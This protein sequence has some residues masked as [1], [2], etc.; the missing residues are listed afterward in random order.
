M[1]KIRTYK[2][3]LYPTKNQVYKLE[4]AIETCRILYNSC[5]VDRRNHYER[6]G[7]G[8]SRI[9]QQRIIVADKAR[10]PLLREVHSQVL[11]DVLFRVERAFKAFFRRL[12]E[13][14]KKAG[15]PRFKGKERYNSITYP[16]KPGFSFKEGKLVLS[17]IGHIKIKMH[18]QIEG[19]VKTCT[20]VRDSDRWYACFS[21]EKMPLRIVPPSNKCIGIDVG[22]KN[23]A[24]LSDGAFIENP[25]YLIKSETKLARL[26]KSLSRKKKGSSNRGKAKLLVAR[27]HQTIRNQRA[28]FHH[29]ISRQ[30]VD[31]YGTITVEDL[32]IRNMVKNHHIAKSISDAGWGLFLAKLAYKAEEAGRLFEKIAPNNTS[33]I[34][35]GC[36]EKVL[37]SLSIRIHKC[38]F[39]GLILDR[40]ENAAINILKRS[41]VG[42]TGSYAWGEAVQL[43]S[44]LNQEALSVRSG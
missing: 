33:Q 26:Q 42:T 8:L 1:S 41:T 31:S 22:I 39:C 25:K 28:D 18:R 9:D 5:L 2:Y 40:D 44:S 34:C 35:S 23:F 12:A 21:I 15:Y 13:K 16:Q 38:P 6:T 17:K 4:N 14:D 3:R 20:I 32:Q 43:G 11:Q 19:K 7:K 24:V 10:M 30:I 29:K 37:K 36:G 27:L